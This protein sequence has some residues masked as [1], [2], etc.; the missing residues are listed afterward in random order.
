MNLLVLIGGVCV[1]ALVALGLYFLITRVTLKST[2]TK[3]V[4]RK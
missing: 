2:P 1:A 3:K 4:N